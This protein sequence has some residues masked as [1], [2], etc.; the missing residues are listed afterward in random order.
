MQ[1]ITYTNLLKCD[2]AKYYFITEFKKIGALPD[3]VARFVPGLKLVAYESYKTLVESYS[4]K[5]LYA[6]GAQLK[7]NTIIYF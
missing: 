2:V 4:D 7:D 5:R 3:E 1:D 6:L